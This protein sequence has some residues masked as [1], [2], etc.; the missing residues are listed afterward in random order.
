MLRRFISTLVIATAVVLAP[1]GAAYAGQAGADHGEHPCVSTPDGRTAAVG[2]PLGRAAECAGVPG[3]GA[4][5][6]GAARGADRRMGLAASG[7]TSIPY[8]ALAGG[9]VVAGV[10]AI[11]VNRIRTRQN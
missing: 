11:V 10:G 3:D 2:E 1:A 9:L 8:L 6:G 5:A 4:G 7:P